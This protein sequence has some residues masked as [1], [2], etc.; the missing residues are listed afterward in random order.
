MNRVIYHLLLMASLLMVSASCSGSKK[1][2][3]QAPADVPQNDSQAIEKNGKVLIV[4]FSHTGENY[5]VGNIKVGNTKLVA[6]EIQR[7]TGGD[8]FEIVPERSYQMPYKELTELAKRESNNNE[9][10]AIKGKVEHLGQYQT[11]F[12]GGPI[13]WGTY[14]QVMFTFFDGHDLNGKTI[15]PFTTHEGS[16]LG[17]TVAD[18]QEI[19]PNATIRDARAFTGHSVRTSMDEVKHWLKELGY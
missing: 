4:F 6:D 13:W 5:A 16:G 11:I 7:A 1:T 14:P 18:L 12:I 8:Q 2:S 3:S 19:Y 15:I 9:R 17:S 10:P